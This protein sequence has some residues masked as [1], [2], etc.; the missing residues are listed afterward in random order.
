MIRQLMKRLSGPSPGTLSGSM[1]KMESLESLFATAVES[2]A[3]AVDSVSEAAGD[4]PRGARDEFRKKLKQLRTTIRTSSSQQSFEE[5]KRQFDAEVKRFGR[6]VEEH[7]Q[8]QERDAKEIMAIVATMADS[9]ASREKQHN[10]RFKGIAR[11]LRLL[12]TSTDLG[13]IRQRLSEE[14]GQLD[15]Y[16]EDMARDTQSALE[17]V[18]ADLEA[19]QDVKRTQPWME[20]A[21]DPVTKLAGRPEAMAALATR[22]RQDPFFCVVLFSVEGYADLSTRQGRPTAE[23]LL[24][25]FALRLKTLLPEATLLARWNEAEALALVEGNLPEV[26]GRALDLERRL[27]GAYAV[28]KAD[29]AADRVSISCVSS[30]LQPLRGESGQQLLERLRAGRR[31]EPALIER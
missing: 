13:E 25:E 11:K 7:A 16:V 4:S 24:K 14:V 10:V 15:K 12:T 29:G 5:C 18:R 26:A 31:R 22:L 21:V 17:R 2:Y 19:R 27:S 20:E 23:S 1:H 9:V 6:L 28:E 3:A 30:V 8:T